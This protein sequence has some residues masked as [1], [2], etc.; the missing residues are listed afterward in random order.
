VDL[1]VTVVDPRGPSPVE[2]ELTTSPGSPLGE[3]L[4]QLLG[5]VGRTEGRLWCGHEEL[6]AGAVL[7]VPPLLDGAVLTVDRPGA[8]GTMPML[9]LHVLAGPDCGAVHRLPPGEHGI[10]RAVE[11]RVRVTDPNVSR[12]HAVLRVGLDGAATTTVHDLGSSN[13]TTLDRAPVDRAGAAVRP[14]QVLRTGDTRFGLMLPESVPVSCRPDGAGHLMLNRPP[15]H[16]SAP[17]AVQVSLPAEQRPRERVRFPLI[18]L[19]LPLVAGVVLVF[20]TRSPTYLLFVLLSPLM[21]LGTYVN[22]RVTTRRARSSQQSDHVAASARS[23]EAVRRGL[24]DEAANRHEAHPDTPELLLCAIGPRPRL[25][26]RRREDEDFLEVRLGLGTAPAALE[27]RTPGTADRAEATHHPSLHDV[28]VTLS[29]ARARVVGVAGPRR[30]L[31]GLARSLTA[32]LAG[33]HSPRHLGLVVLC[34]G[35]RADWAWARWLPHL[36]PV[37]GEGCTSLVGVTPDQVRTRVDELVSLLDRRSADMSAGGTGLWSGR[38]VVVVLDGAHALRRLPG[39]VRIL[40][41]GPDVGVFALCLET[42]VVSLPAE[43]RATAEVPEPSRARMLVRDEHGTT[44][45]GVVP[46]GVH[47]RW[48]TRFSRALAPLRDSTPD[49]RAVDLPTRARLLDLLPVDAT[50]AAAVQTAWRESPR[51]TSVPLGVAAGGEPF[52]VDLATDGPHVLVAGTTGSGK[53][54]LLQTLV[55]GLAVANR[56]DE[57][58]FVLIDYKGGAAF[59]D[60]ARLPH[61]VG[62]VTD[63]DSRLTERA[64]QSL[65]AELRRREQLLASAGSTD[66]DDYLRDA[67]PG[68]S[69][70]ARLVLVV[71]EFAT[72]VDELPDFVGGLVGIAQRGRSLGVHLVLATQRPGGVVSADIRANTGLRIALRVT[73]AAESQDVVDVRDA[74]DI[75]RSTPGRAIARTESGG[76]V[77]LQTARVGGQ[78]GMPCA[79]PVARLVSWETVGD[80]RPPAMAGTSSG[81][82][83]LSL[84]VAAATEAARSLGVPR[85]ATPWQAPLPSEITTAALEKALAGVGGAGVTDGVTIGLRDLP[86]EQRRAPITLGLDG[87][88]HLLVAGGAR[89]GRS[90]LLRTVAGALAERFD[91]RDLHLYALD[92]GGGALSALAGLPHCGAVVGR[93]ESARGDRLLTLLVDEVERRQQLLA[94]SGWASTEEQRRLARPDDRL[95][96]VVLLVDSWEGLQIAYEDVDHGRPLDVLARLVR[97]GATVGYRVVLTGGR[98]VLTSRVGSSFHDRLVLR[99]P[100]ATDYGLA[101]IA[102]RRVPPDLPPGR[103]LLTD[104]SEAQVALLPGDPSGAGQVAAIEGIAE[105]ARARLTASAACAVD[106]PAGPGPGPLRVDALPSR[107]GFDDL[108]PAAEEQSTNRGWALLGIGGDR[109]HPLGVDLVVDGPAFVI[110]G[111]PG[112]GRSTTLATVARW[113]GQHGRPTVVVAPRR[114]PLTAL[115]GT[116]GVIACLGPADGEVLS[117]LLRTRADLTVLADDAETLHDTRVERP[118]LTLLHPDAEGVHAVVLAGSAGEMAGCF[119]GLTVEARRGRTGLLLGRLG[120]GESDLLGLRLPPRPAGPTGRGLLVVRG[121]VTH[122]QVAHTDL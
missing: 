95:P 32:Q 38:S 52:L 59:A 15:R 115:A 118:L 122:V 76:V 63:L 39:V 51:S 85:A 105:R 30:E 48:A 54:E 24:A 42:D 31:L 10:G 68:A 58:S 7:G 113:L 119:R 4:A 28:P 110:A 114:S 94:S 23:D 21:V 93:D 34:A 74:A 103:A 79:P 83:D 3:V 88:N 55:A 117:E 80:P 96:W 57:L 120:P 89:S 29:I 106:A 104:G 90:T 43:C 40:T 19:A 100:D 2:V 65:G 75:S 84:I 8:T 9:E 49:D 56:P 82:S 102:L 17:A 44:Y 66:L 11:A 25:W 92:A 53:S 69:P 86:R 47:E 73:D 14:G 27:V 67:P 101:G 108:A 111:P 60:C 62:M 72:L 71:D 35:A 20:V 64:L 77:Q 22:D 109:L 6:D 91:V 50:S 61:T 1:T 45:A 97:E 46:D 36:E 5:P 26:E 37:R 107:I 81:P 112:S 41:E 78:N 98:A 16:V 70:L 116:P 121:Q 12:L 87:G 99:M 13:G 33:W 18:A